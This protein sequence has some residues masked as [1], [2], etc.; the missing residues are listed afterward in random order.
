[1]LQDS[2]SGPA[3]GPAGIDATLLRAVAETAISGVILIDARN[4]VLMFNPACK[5]LFEYSAD[6]VIGQNVKMLMPSPYREA[7]DNYLDN[8]HQ[9]GLRKIIGIGR[10]MFGRRKSGSTFPMDLA[11]PVPSNVTFISTAFATPLQRDTAG[12]AIAAIHPRFNRMFFD[13]AVI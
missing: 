7:H 12:A 13:P 11:D 3:P 5:G 4:C 2:R 8:F 6:D 10:E 1:M 9:T